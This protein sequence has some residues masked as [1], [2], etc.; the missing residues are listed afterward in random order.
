[1][2]ETFAEQLATGVTGAVQLEASVLELLGVL[3]LRAAVSPGA[4]SGKLPA[5]LL[6]SPHFNADL[7]FAVGVKSSRN[8]EVMLLLFTAGAVMAEIVGAL[9]MFVVEE[10]G[11]VAEVVLIVVMDAAEAVSVVVAAIVQV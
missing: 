5:R 1:V 8:L 9:A 11:V 3:M 6:V 2:R 7:V 4:Q 10:V